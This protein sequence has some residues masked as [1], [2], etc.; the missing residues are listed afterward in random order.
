MRRMGVSSARVE[1]LFYYFFSKNK[2]NF[3]PKRE[4]EPDGSQLDSVVF[5]WVA[6]AFHECY[7]DLLQKRIKSKSF[8]RSGNQRRK[9]RRKLAEEKQTYPSELGLDLG[10][11]LEHRVG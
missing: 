9:K 7:P 6:E 4:C 2:K 3:L 5:H 1:M 11:H 8:V 10:E